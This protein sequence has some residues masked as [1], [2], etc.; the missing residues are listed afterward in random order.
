MEY[1]TDATKK[2][3]KKIKYNAVA[4]SNNVIQDLRITA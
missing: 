2:S 4:R 3:S 1:Y